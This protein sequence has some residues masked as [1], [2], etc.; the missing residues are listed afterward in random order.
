MSKNFEI[1]T[2]AGG[3]FWCTEAI[4]KRIV[5][6]K[7]VLPGYSGGSLAHPSYEDVCS[8]STGHAEAIQITFDRTKIS[9]NK[10]LDIFWDTHNPTTK[11]RQGNDI[12]T[13]YRSIIFYHDEK[14][15][16]IAQ[17]SKE[18]LQKAEIYKDPIVT[19]ILQFTA[20]YEAENYHKN[21]YEN[22]KDT[23]YCD[24]VIGPKIH[25]FLKKYGR[26]IKGEY[27]NAR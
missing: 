16:K 2:L 6:V 3:C 17:K 24:L 20:F 12:G 19:E 14:Q 8:G 10:I 25:K 22:N 9:F 13:Q 23:V 27:K 21:Y 4:F 18:E 1:A 5:G 7:T 26:D 11:N 15:R